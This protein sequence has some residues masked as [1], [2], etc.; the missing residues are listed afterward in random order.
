MGVPM[1]MIIRTASLAVVL[2]LRCA[3]AEVTDADAHGF[4][5]V[6]ELIINAPP[7]RVWSAAIN[8]I[9]RWWH[10]DHTISGDAGR[11][12]ITASVQGCFCETLGEGAGVVHLA[13]TMVSPVSVLRM[14]GGLG[15]LGLM[16]VNG[17]MTWEFEPENEGTKAKFSY[18]VGGYRKGGLDAISGPVDFVIGE[19]LARMKSYIETGNPE[20]ANIE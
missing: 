1:E 3:N 4:T 15:P 17:N 13:V 7:D 18:A 14:T 20:V 9:D 10:P 2:C 8:D 6:T 19:A 11:L 5:T 12:S 16:G